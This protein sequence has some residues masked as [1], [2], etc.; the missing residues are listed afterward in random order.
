MEYGHDSAYSRAYILFIT[1]SFPYLGKLSYFRLK[2]SKYEKSK[3]NIENEKCLWRFHA[4]YNT[5]C[6]PVFFFCTNEVKLVVIL[7]Y[8]HFD[9]CPLVG[10]GEFPYLVVAAR[11]HFTWADMWCE[12]GF[13]PYSSKPYSTDKYLYWIWRHQ[14]FSDRTRNEQILTAKVFHVVLQLNHF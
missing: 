8:S 6:S 12:Y 14:P 11:R 9:G 5:D 4:S 2:A 3:K 10:S 7:Y 1:T 13:N